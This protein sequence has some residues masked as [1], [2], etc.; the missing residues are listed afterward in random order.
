MRWFDEKFKKEE[1]EL[2]RAKRLLSGLRLNLPGVQERLEAAQGSL[3]E[4]HRFAIRLWHREIADAIQQ[5]CQ[6]KLGVVEMD[7]KKPSSSAPPLLYDLTSLQRD[8]NGR[9]GYSAKNTLG[10]AQTLYERHKV[11]T[12]P[13]T[14][15]RALPED[16]I[17]TV[18][19]TLEAMSDSH[20]AASP[21][22]SCATVGSDPANAF[23]TTPRCPITSPS[24]LPR[25]SPNIWPSTNR[26]CM[27][28]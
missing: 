28:W 7:E 27:I 22:K 13:R 4:D 26:N 3:W 24:S 20:Y 10:L 6:G 1:S 9:F 8:A 5:K 23:S 17:A 2:D 14:D 25:S 15:S 19:T 16:Y 18:K 21:A 11:L 12:Y